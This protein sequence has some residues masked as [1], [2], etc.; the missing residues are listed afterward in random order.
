[1]TGSRC[2]G[3]LLAVGE[4]LRAAKPIDENRFHEISSRAAGNVAKDSRCTTPS[5]LPDHRI[6]QIDEER[7]P[8]DDEQRGK[9]HVE[10]SPEPGSRSGLSISRA[11]LR[12]RSSANDRGGADSLIG[13]FGPALTWA[14]THTAKGMVGTSKNSASSS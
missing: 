4:N 12:K 14:A 7:S 5:K 13:N 8:E 11:V 2:R 1:L 6:G 10:R 9:R 3:G